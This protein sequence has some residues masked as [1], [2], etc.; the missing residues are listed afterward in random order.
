VCDRLKADEVEILGKA[1]RR[2]LLE[3]YKADRP[4][5]LATG[6]HRPQG[7]RRTVSSAGR[8]A[9]PDGADR[10]PGAFARIMVRLGRRHRARGRVAVAPTAYR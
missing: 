6:T 5:R 7:G 9:F 3:I 1:L 2:G 10:L 8:G 4:A